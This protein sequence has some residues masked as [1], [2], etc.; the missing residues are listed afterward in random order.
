MF[1]FPYRAHGF[2]TRSLSFYSN[3]IHRSLSLKSFKLAKFLHAQLIK[4]GFNR[5]TFLG[6]RCTDLY[7]NL[8]ALNDSLQAFDE[9]RD[10]NIVSWNIC[11]KAL[12]KH[13]YLD[14]ACLLFDKMSERDVVSW[15]TVISGYASRGY[16]DYVFV[17]LRK[18]RYDGCWPD[19]F[20]YSIL[21][22]ASSWTSFSAKQIHASMIR[23]EIDV[24][25]LIVGNSLIDMYGKVGLLDY[26]LSVIAA[27]K[28]IDLV[29]WN[30]LIY[31]CWN[32]GYGELA[33]DQFFS[34][35]DFG[36][37]PDAYT[38][39]MMAHICNGLRDLEKGK[40][41]FAFCIKLGLLSNAIVSS[42]VIYLFSK[43]NRFDDSIHLFT[44]INTLDKNPIVS[45]SI[46]SSYCRHGFGENAWQIFVMNLRDNVMPSEFTLSTLLSLSPT[47]NMS[48]NH[49]IQIHSLVFKLGMENDSV[50]S[51]SLVEMYSN[52]GLIDDAKR[53][54]ENIAVKDL[55][56]WNIMVS[57]LACNGR[58]TE[59]LET[60]RVMINT[61][62][63][64]DHITLAGVLLACRHGGLCNE[65]MAIFSC[66]EKEFGVSRREEHY[67]S[68]VEIM[69]RAGKYK[70]ALEIAEAIPYEPTPSIWEPILVACW[71]NFDLRIAE[72]A[73]ERM[74]KY[75]PHSALPYLVLARIYERRCRWENVI[76]VRKDM[77]RMSRKLIIGCSWIGVRNHVVDFREDDSFVLENKDVY[78]ILKFLAWGTSEVED[79]LSS[80]YE[81]THL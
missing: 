24:S 46:I 41:F 11:L 28:I 44:D 64:P 73:A 81:S 77:K 78:S 61:G 74:M 48:S 69:C 2:H 72:R 21:M 1:V 50:V 23:N 40:K 25:Q 63:S 9:I 22:S 79:G 31:G 57:G 70:T 12:V 42:A 58:V 51:T 15:N 8:G 34:M 37:S 59:A 3:L 38:L 67:V 26:A 39:S 53:L 33:F 16:S 71:A 65:G 75:E 54:F 49:W 5:H 36:Y 60:F 7:S 27:M 66:M 45:H 68:M 47:L 13:G 14:R 20:T 18:M 4:V 80:V 10:K 56:C 35:M 52:L 62:L 43:C 30:S 6:N 76:Q 55:I 17:L 19:G 32:S 29:S